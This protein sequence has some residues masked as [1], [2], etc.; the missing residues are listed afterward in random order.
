MISF[1]Q[2]IDPKIQWLYSILVPSIVTAIGWI[3]I[4]YSGRKHIK[5]EKR[6]IIKLDAY[7]SVKSSL[8]NL[9]SAYSQLGSFIVVFKNNLDALHADNELIKEIWYK[10]KINMFIDEY[11][12]STFKNYKI[13]AENGFLEF[14]RSWEMHELILKPLVNQRHALQS[15]HMEI[16]NMISWLHTDYYASLYTLSDSQHLNPETVKNLYEKFNDADDRL[17]DFIGCLLDICFNMQNYVFG[18]VLNDKIAKR[19]V[20]DDKYLTIDKLLKKHQ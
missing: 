6:I 19:K 12:S 16:S 11:K 17:T 1:F 3:Y 8:G 9:I 14:I 13:A 18:E 20:M 7:S 5:E 2:Q 4:F 15:E 10:S